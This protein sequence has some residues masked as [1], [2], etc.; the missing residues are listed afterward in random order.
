MYVGDVAREYW[1][2]FIVFF[3]HLVMVCRRFSDG[4]RHGGVLLPVCYYFIWAVW[5]MVGFLGQRVLISL[6]PNGEIMM[7]KSLKSHTAPVVGERRKDQAPRGIKSWLRVGIEFVMGALVM[8]LVFILTPLGA[9][10]VPRDASSVIVMAREKLQPPALAK[11]DGAR[12]PDPDELLRR[13]QAQAAKGRQSKKP[14]KVK[15]PLAE[16]RRIEEINARNRSM[17]ARRTGLPGQSHSHSHPHPQPGVR[18][19]Q[20]AVPQPYQPVSPRPVAPVYPGHG[21]P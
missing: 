13:A 14:E 7:S 10:C 19:P 18:R 11:S 15:D 21:R 4:M 3:P 12:S 1:D 6:P 9:L 17:M 8:F 16:L 5:V 20:P 2:S